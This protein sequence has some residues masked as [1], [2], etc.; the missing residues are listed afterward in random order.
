[1]VPETRV[2]G[3]TLGFLCPVLTTAAGIRRDWALPVRRSPGARSRRA[4]MAQTG[5]RSLTVARG[6]IREGSLFRENAAA[7]VGLGEAQPQPVRHADTVATCAADE[8]G[9]GRRGVVSQLVDP[10]SAQ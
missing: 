6:Y 4:I 3:T 10:S 7:R 1:M 8:P 9:P 2:L 5:H